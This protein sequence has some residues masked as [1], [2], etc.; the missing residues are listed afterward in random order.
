MASAS[1][2]AAPFTELA[3]FHRELAA[4]LGDHD[5]PIVFQVTD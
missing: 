1:K 2:A 3:A 5:G 4:E